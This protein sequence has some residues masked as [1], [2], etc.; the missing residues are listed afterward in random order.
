MASSS[1]NAAPTA[2]NAERS[3]PTSETHRLSQVRLTRRRL[4]RALAGGA[5]VL[6]AS[7]RRG[8][9]HTDATNTTTQPALPPPLPT[10]TR[11]AIATAS[12]TPTRAT[13]TPRARPTATPSA[14][15]QILYRGGFLTEPVSHDFN[16]NLYCGGDPSLWSGL[17]TLN[18][19]LTPMA[20]WA[21]AWEPNADASHWTFHLQRGNHGWSNGDPVTAQDFVW[22]WQ[23]LLNPATNAPHAWLLFDMLNAVQIHSGEMPPEKLGVT[24]TDN[25]TLSVDL[26]GPRIYFP[27]I[28]ATVGTAP[29]YRPAVEQFG[30]DWTD[31]PHI[32]T[33]G[34]FTL[35]EWQHGSEWTTVKN[36]RYWNEVNIQL[37]ETT[38]PLSPVEKHAQPYFDFQVDFMPVQPT[39]LANVR[40]ISDLNGSLTGSVDPAIWFLM[41]APQRPP[42]DNLP[43]RQAVAH[44]LDRERLVQLSEGRASVAK[45]LLPTTF[46]ARVA[47]NDVRSLQDFDVGKALQLLAGTPFANGSNWPPVTLLTTDT[48]E[49]AQLLANDCAAQLI[50]NIGLQ[51]DVTTVALDEYN[52][53]LKAGTAGLFWSRWDFTYADANNGYADAF[54]PIGANDSRL[55]AP[56]P[57]LGELVGRGKVEPNPIARAAIY[58]DAEIALQSAVS[59][60]PIAYPVT[61]YLVR[62]WVAGFPLASDASL[63]Q[64]G[65][66]FTRLTSL[67]N[68]QDKPPT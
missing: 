29:A 68:I 13:P 63:L 55:P 45:S 51:V 59:Y 39:D 53:A 4:F 50:E 16:A 25:W 24:A 26:V 62:P 49:V 19:D 23:R 27:S 20:D 54:Y 14:S 40:S 8:T 34:P 61:F 28:V 3:A 41:V 60:I 7:C 33:N 36:A 30:K 35:N 48:S 64:P 37:D 1:P 42:F 10:P 67:V 66:L 56:P 38:V 2:I 52:V 58:R 6:T 12:A 11:S 43:V 21:L 17:L 31:A 57:N 22:S 18:T 9:A 47:D 5:V 15:A 46:P 65:T 32:V 44:A